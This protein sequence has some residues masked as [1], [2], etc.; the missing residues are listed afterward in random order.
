MASLDTEVLDD[1]IGEYAYSCVYC[2][3]WSPEWVVK[4]ED[5]A[6]IVRRALSEALGE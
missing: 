4:Q 2:P 3:D 6:T 5:V 1:I